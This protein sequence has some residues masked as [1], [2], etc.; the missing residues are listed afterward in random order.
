MERGVAQEGKGRCAHTNFLPSK[1]G[2]SLPFS[3]QLLPNFKLH[4]MCSW[5][6]YLL[7]TML[8]FEVQLD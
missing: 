7:A 8:Q 3:G 4:S 1:A 5:R 2:M 6:S